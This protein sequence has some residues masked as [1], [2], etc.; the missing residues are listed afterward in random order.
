MSEILR[1]LFYTANQDRRDAFAERERFDLSEWSP[2][3]DTR[4]T[5]EQRAE[6]AERL[7]HASRKREERTA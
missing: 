7:R 2:C 5:S 4:Q 1:N 6:R 3:L